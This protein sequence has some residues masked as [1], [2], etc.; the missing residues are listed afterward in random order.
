MWFFAG[1]TLLDTIGSVLSVLISFAGAVLG[2]DCLGA[3]YSA[4]R[5][6]SKRLE[7]ERWLLD[8]WRPVASHIARVASGCSHEAHDAVWG[9]HV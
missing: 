7:D 8:N 3:V 2:L 6:A 4:Y 5:R 1:G 9:G